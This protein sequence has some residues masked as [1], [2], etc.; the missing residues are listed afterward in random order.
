[1]ENYRCIAANCEKSKTCGHYNSRKI[2]REEIIE[3][4]LSD[5]CLLEYR[6]YTYY[7]DNP[8]QK[9]SCKEVYKELFDF[10]DNKCDGENCSYQK[11][12]KGIAIE[13][14]S[15]IECKLG[16]HITCK[17]PNHPT[18]KAFNIMIECIM[19]E[20][21]AF[22]DAGI[23]EGTVTYT[24]PRCGSEAVGNRYLHGGRYHGLG[25]GCKKCGMW[26]T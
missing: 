1:M 15:C 17:N 3:E 8:Y 7:L 16:E 2:Y 11:G 24:C 22:E 25:S 4:D 18:N 20:S 10:Y 19:A 13:H 9:Y 26:H 12:Y 14:S 5:I 23:T 6:L 21:K